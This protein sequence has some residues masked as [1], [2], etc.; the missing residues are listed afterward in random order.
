MMFAHDILHCQL[1]TGIALRQASTLMNLSHVYTHHVLCSVSH[2]FSIA[3]S[4]WPMQY[5]IIPVLLQCVTGRALRVL[6]CPRRSQ[7]SSMLSSC[8][9]RTSKRNRSEVFDCGHSCCCKC[10]VVR[11]GAEQLIQAWLA[12]LPELVLQYRTLLWATIF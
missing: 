5:A 2:P 7:R 12:I 4:P 1:C 10:V 9:S 3:I 8:R 6:N 11:G